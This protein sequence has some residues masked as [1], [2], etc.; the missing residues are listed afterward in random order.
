MF[1]QNKPGQQTGFG[2]LGAPTSTSASGS[3]GFTAGA[4]N[5]GKYSR[6]KEVRVS[7][8]PK[9]HLFVQMK[10]EVNCIT[11]LLPSSSSPFKSHLATSLHLHT[12]INNCFNTATDD[13]SKIHK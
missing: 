8:R 4:S 11:L 3:F 9:S 5:S 13:I 6:T 2:S 12:K 10:F 1:G 7:L